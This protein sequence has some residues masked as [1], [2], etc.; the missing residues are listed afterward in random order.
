MLKKLFI[1][2]FALME[3]LNLEFSN[4]FNVLTG[5]TGAGKSMVINALN[6][7]LGEKVS[8][9]MLRS[10]TD[11]AIVEGVFH[12]IPE[13][14]ESFLTENEIDV[15]ENELILRREL[16][17]SG[18]SR[19]FINDCITQISILK[20]TSEILVDLHGQHEHQSLLKTDNHYEIIDNFANLDHLSKSIKNQYD[21]II[22]HQQKLHT[23]QSEAVTVREKQEFIRF[24]INEIESLNLYSGEDEEL[25]HEEKVLA[26]YEKLS[27]FCNEIYKILYDQEHAAI[28]TIDASINKLEELEIIDQAFSNVTK[29]LRTANIHIE[30]AA[31]FVNDYLFKA[32]FDQERLEN[33][34]VRLSE[35]QRIQK[36]YGKPIPE[37]L[38]KVESL[39][40]ELAE[41]ENLD[42]TLESLQKQLSTRKSE[43]QSFCVELSEKRKKS[44]TIFQVQIENIIRQIGMEN[45]FVKIVFES[46]SPNDGGGILLP[47]GRIAKQNGID[48]IE[49]Y[50][51]TNL[52]EGFKPL[53]EVASG[54]EISRIML[55]IKSVLAGKD[56]IGVLVFDEID[57]GISGRIAESVGRKLK[58][59]SAT[60]QVICVT[61]LPQIASFADKHFSVRKIVSNGTT[62]THVQEL[63]R[64]DRV[65]EIASLIGGE[66]VTDTVIKNAE[67][68]LNINSI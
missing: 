38:E 27:S 12:S 6:T 39:N 51:S 22:E 5:E 36:K 46:F 16:N 15:F 11:K 29:N 28:T 62:I 10:G 31:R 8:P 32:E 54:G 21:G 61:H 24:Q 7:I 59:L 52:G 25:S 41:I 20:N 34:R 44:A 17:E 30:E 33:I 35:I 56:K 55:A 48:N 58:E 68:M 14:I 50:V 47:D 43:L 13:K 64:T 40:K 57:I 4:G 60:H 65:K 23:L 37:I 53:A 42:K 49:L 67:E 2:N 26:N 19:T 63:A 45:A 1:K 66:N 9:G 3:E 18:R